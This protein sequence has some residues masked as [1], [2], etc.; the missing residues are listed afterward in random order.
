MIPVQ[1]DLALTLYGYYQSPY[2][3]DG[4]VYS[5]EKNLYRTTAPWHSDDQTQKK[6]SYYISKIPFKN[7]KLHKDKHNADLLGNSAIKI[8]RWPRTSRETIPLRM[9]SNSNYNQL[10]LKKVLKKWQW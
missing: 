1:E 6:A 10:S 9:H 7:N 4:D 3:K 8:I 2:R 5:W